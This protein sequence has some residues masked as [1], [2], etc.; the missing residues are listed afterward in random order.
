MSRPLTRRETTAVFLSVG[1][2]AVILV[3]SVVWPGFLAQPSSTC[4][5]TGVPK[6]T[7]NDRT[8]CFE[9]V[10]LTAARLTCPLGP[11]DNW[12]GPS[13]TVSFWGAQFNLAPYSCGNVTGTAIKIAEPNGN[14]TFAA[15][16]YGCPPGCAIVTGDF[17]DDWVAGVI[18]GFPHESYSE[19]LYVETGA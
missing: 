17:T 4:P 8:Y 7:L 6:Q 12:S 5:L 15:T 13:E 18:D 14:V 1:V 19:T 3:V 16:E 9:Y 10:G 11:S 2:A